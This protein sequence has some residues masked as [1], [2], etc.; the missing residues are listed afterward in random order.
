MEALSRIYEYSPRFLRSL[1]VNVFGLRNVPRF[2]KWNDL[3]DSIEHTETMEKQA[4]IVLIENALRETIRHA[5]EKVP[6][7]K[8]FASLAPDLE[9][10]SVFDI[11]KEFPVIDKEAIIVD[12]SAFYADDYGEYV[13][14]KTSGTTG[15][16]LSVRMDPYTFI[17]GDALWWRRTR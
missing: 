7:Y 13:I 2:R 12:P 14:S 10:R 5:V 1:Y 6:F 15:T 11:L 4:Q 9:S 16:P 17:L 3:L 8:K